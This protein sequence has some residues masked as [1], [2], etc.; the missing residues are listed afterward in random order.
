MTDYKQ[1][2]EDLTKYLRLRTFPVGFKFFEKEEDSK[3]LKGRRKLPNKLKTCQMITLARV[4]GW[5]IGAT[6]DDFSD[7]DLS[8]HFCTPYLGLRPKMEQVADGTTRSLVWFK[9]KKDGLKCETEMPCIPAGKFKAIG[10]AP[11]AGEK[12]EPDV[13]LLYGTPAQ[14]I[15]LINA[16]QW[17]NYEQMVF[18]C[19]G[20]SACNDSLVR[21]YLTQKP[22][23]TVPCFGERQFA[24]V[25]EEELVMGIPPKMLE[26]IIEGLKGLYSRGIRYPIPSLAPQSDPSTVMPEEYRNAA[27]E[28][29]KKNN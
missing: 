27:A 14:M 25:Q 23:L 29:L 21:C 26:K 18:H 22:Q 20:E 24:A 28:F 9:D 15:I 6:L 19:V 16:I 2:S 11:I 17:E 7:K 8:N 4:N 12:F 5:T 10:I 1:I 13:V 3:N